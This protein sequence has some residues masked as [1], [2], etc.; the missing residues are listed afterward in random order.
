MNTPT[1][2][3]QPTP[4]SGPVPPADD[5]TFAGVMRSEEVAGEVRGTHTAEG[6]QALKEN[7]R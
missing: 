5:C 7:Q 2:P 1:K 6:Q 3:K 4:G